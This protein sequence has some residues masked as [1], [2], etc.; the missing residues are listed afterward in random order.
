MNN[1]LLAL[2]IFIIVLGMPFG[3]LLT[4]NID[5]LLNFLFFYPMFMSGLWIAGGLYF[6]WHWESKW[7]WGEAREVP[8]LSGNPLVSILIPCHNEVEN[9]EETL[10]SALYQNYSNIEVIAI[11]DGSTDGSGELL[12]RMALQHER[13]RIVHLAHNQGKAMALRMGA[14]AARSDYLVCIDGDAM[15]DVDAV[16]Y[17]VAPLLKLPRVGAVTGNPRIRTRSTLIGQ[18]QVGE[19]S[20]IIGLIKRTQRVYGQV[21]TVSGVVAAF[22]RS[23]LDRIGYWD[24]DMITEDIDISWKLQRDHWSVFYE[25][26]ALCWI[27]M[28]ETLRG[29]WRQRLRWAQGGAEV[30]LKNLNIVW[31]WRNRRL[32]PLVLEYCMSVFWAFTFAISILLWLINKVVVLPDFLYVAAIIP[33]G[34]TGMMLAVTC[35]AQFTTSILIDSRYEPELP[36]SLYWIVWYPLAYWMLSLSTT[37]VSFAK[38][39]LRNKPH[40][41]ARWISP[42]RGIKPPRAI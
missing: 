6:W 37:L 20:S 35:L 10:L 34:F 1:R 41:Q 3:I 16:S 17:L 9:A 42:D 26:R 4:L 22:R 8:K 18:I 21:F 38:V 14:L 7:G 5:T 30:F 11:N 31:H 27:L 24:L 28:P 29:L 12:N 13:L 15:L 32:W 23:A 2:L 19:F 40:Q 36:H 39:M 25:P 33:P